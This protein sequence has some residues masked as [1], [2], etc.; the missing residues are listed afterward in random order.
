LYESH[1]RK[2]T[3][4]RTEKVFYSSRRKNNKW[5]RLISPHCMHMAYAERR[6]R[7]EGRAHAET[8]LI[9]K[10]WYR[11]SKFNTHEGVPWDDDVHS[12]LHV[13]RFL[14]MCEKWHFAHGM[15]KRE[16]VFL[17]WHSV[18]F[19]HFYFRRDIYLKLIRQKH[20]FTP[21]LNSNFYH[22]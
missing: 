17:C 4:K 2:R 16:E 3:E 6:G 22:L 8:N 14:Q 13:E 9:S 18:R 20:V 10:T 7:G 21:Q 19:I 1:E 11:N 5:E 15:R 12:F